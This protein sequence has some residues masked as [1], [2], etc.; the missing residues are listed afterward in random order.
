VSDV[1]PITDPIQLRDEQAADYVKNLRKLGVELKHADAQKIAI[2]DLE[3]VDQVNRE[4]SFSKPSSEPV[5]S[6][7][8]LEELSHMEDEDPSKQMA[9]EGG[10]RF[11]RRDPVD[12]PDIETLSHIQFERRQKLIRRVNLLMTRD[13]TGEFVYRQFAHMLRDVFIDYILFRRLFRG[14]HVPARA[15]ERDSK[16]FYL[17]SRIADLSNGHPHL[18]PWDFK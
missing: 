8:D 14:M 15:K 18:P 10:M 6:D 11:A 9:Q 7:A 5:Y 13:G 16:L 1:K 3:M 17:Y 4:P 2:R 12:V